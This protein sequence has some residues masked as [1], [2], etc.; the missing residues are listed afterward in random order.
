[1]QMEPGETGKPIW[2]LDGFWWSRIDEMILISGITMF[3]AFRF[4]PQAAFLY[5]GLWV[6]CGPKLSVATAKIRWEKKHKTTVK[7]LSY[8][9][10]MCIYYVDWELFMCVE[11]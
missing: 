8:E 1:M 4:P 3:C 6:D 9:P 7:T 5:K 11:V 2:N 10:C